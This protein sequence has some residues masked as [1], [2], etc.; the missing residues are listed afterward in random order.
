MKFKTIATAALIAIS[1]IA[2][3]AGSL[4]AGM[5]EPVVAPADDDDVLALGLFGSLGGGGVAAAAALAVIA[6]A[7]SSGTGT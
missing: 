4:G 6:I 7:A 3:S 1:P 2:A 5:T